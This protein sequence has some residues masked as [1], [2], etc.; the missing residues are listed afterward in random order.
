[1]LLYTPPSVSTSIPVVDLA[2]SFGGH[3][4]GRAT[5][6]D[7]IHMAARQT[8]FFYVR[9]HGIDRSLVEGAFAQA[10]RFFAQ[11]LEQK[12]AV[13]Q[14]PG[15]ARGYERLEGQMLDKGSPGDL[16]EGY[17]CAADL[18]ADHP[19]ASSTLPEVAPNQWPA[20]PGFRAELMAYYVPMLD[21]GLH[22]M[23]L[24]AL[25][26]DM[27][28]SF[29]DDAFRYANPALRVH[30]YPPQP[31][32]AAFNQLGAGAH[33]DWG[34]ITLLAQD[35]N[36]GLEVQNAAGEWIRAE[37][38]DDTFVINLGDMIA[39]WTNDLYHSTMHRVMND[40]TGAERAS[41]AL[42]YNPHYHTHVECLPTCLPKEGAPT[43][44]PCTAGDH[45][46]EKRLIALGLK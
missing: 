8:G 42:F 28:E 34:V 38:I 30:R 32:N 16:K 29:F 19:F 15:S 3:P 43:Y 35:R 33:T 6:A 9:N 13:A 40:R 23:R 36:G 37:P 4:A 1:M 24:I 20:L 11:P 26:L 5:V 10:R 41:M 27:P 31:A 2:P 46:Q 21:L 25:S 22:L 14:I 7:E 12:L 44:A 45:I 17:T 39:R 18:P